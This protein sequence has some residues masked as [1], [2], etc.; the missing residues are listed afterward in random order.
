L[1]DGYAFGVDDSG[2]LP[3]LDPAPMWRALLDDLQAGAPTAEIAARFHAG[4]AD[5]VASLAIALAQRHGVDSIALSGGV[6]QNKTLFERLCTRIEAAGLQALT[7]RQVPANDGGLAL[8]QAVI[9]AAHGIGRQ[10]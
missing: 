9:A 3:Q 7:H 1:P 6:M 10:T 2:A 5:A 8:G 4:L